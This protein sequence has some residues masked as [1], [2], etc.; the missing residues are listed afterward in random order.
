MARKK[1]TKIILQAKC[2]TTLKNKVI[3]YLTIYFKNSYNMDNIQYT[4]FIYVNHYIVIYTQIN[5]CKIAKVSD[6][7]QY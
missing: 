1:I 2:N 5:L 4:L 3:L 6:N 7:Y